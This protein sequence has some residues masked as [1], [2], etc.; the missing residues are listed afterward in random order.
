MYNKLYTLI[1]EDIMDYIN[2]SPRVMSGATRAYRKNVRKSKA[3]ADKGLRHGKSWQKSVDAVRNTLHTI[4]IGK[5]R[6]R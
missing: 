1:L 3:L 4:P 5:K 6:M 2:S